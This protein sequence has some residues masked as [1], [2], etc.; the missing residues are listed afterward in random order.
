MLVLAVGGAILLDASAIVTAKGLGW[1]AL[2]FPAM[3]L[4]PFAAILL[5]AKSPAKWW[6]CGAYIGFMA[7]MMGGLTLGS[8]WPV[9]DGPLAVLPGLGLAAV[10]SWITDLAGRAWIDPPADDAPPPGSGSAT[11]PF[12]G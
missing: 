3:I 11:G 8:R 6:H 4:V 7:G 1:G 9:W 12:P 2:A 10:L 5:F